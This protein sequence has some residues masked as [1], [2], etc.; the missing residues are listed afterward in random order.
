MTKLA[1]ILFLVV[2][3]LSCSTKDKT[4]EESKAEQKTKKEATNQNNEWKEVMSSIVKLESFDG[5]RILES[6]QGFFVGKDLIVTKYALVSQATKV[7]VTPLD[8]NKKYLAEKFVAFDRINDLIIL[9]VEGIQRKPI[10]LAGSVPNSA[11][12]LSIITLLSRI[13]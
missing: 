13:R 9:K 11:K 8:E 10:E 5:E 4:K 7:E 2:I 12:S 6:G 3:F 1:C